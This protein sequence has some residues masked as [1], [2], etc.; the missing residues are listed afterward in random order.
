M[1]PMQRIA[2]RNRISC[3]GVITANR[4][5]ALARCV[6]SFGQRL[7]IMVC[8]QFGKDKY[9]FAA[10]LIATGFS[11]DIV[12]FGLFGIDGAGQPIGANRNALLLH[13][14]GEIAFYVDDD[15]VAHVFEHPEIAPGVA[16]VSSGN[17]S[18]IWFFPDFESARSAATFSEMDLIDAHERLIGRSVDDCVAEGL[19]DGPTPPPSQELSNPSTYGTG[20]LVVTISGVVGDSGYGSNAAYLAV[21]GPSRARLL[22]SEKSYQSALASRYV[23]R[24]PQT[25][26]ISD[27]TIAM[28]Y[29]M[30]VDQR[31]IVPP[32]FPVGRNE[33]GVFGALVQ[34]MYPPGA[35]GY[36]PYAVLHDPPEPRRAIPPWTTVGRFTTTGLTLALLNGIQ[37]PAGSPGTR[38]RALGTLLVEMGS[39]EQ[40]EFDAMAMGCLREALERRISR[41]ESLIALFGGE[42]R[43]WAD[44]CRRCVEAMESASMNLDLDI[45][46]EMARMLIRSYG[47]LI[48]VWQDMLEAAKDLRRK[49]AGLIEC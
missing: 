3:I 45:S 23:I 14:T 24:V 13:N 44:D 25:Y 41:F 10:S 30:A 43:F 11:P 49:G 26:A 19:S 2:V 42:P 6:G 7:P 12:N 33:D 46:L 22:E 28:A 34:I 16:L 36:V 18:T 27:R 38:L 48:T 39:L 15:V 17:P 29:G 47:E 8:D 32:F 5:L 40:R 21:R 35:F 31:D 1:S 9:R 37:I 20:K 4:P